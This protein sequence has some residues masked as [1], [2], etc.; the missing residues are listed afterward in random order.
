MQLFIPSGECYT[1]VKSLFKRTHLELVRVM[2]QTFF[3][4]YARMFAGVDHIELIHDEEDKDY[5]D[6]DRKEGAETRLI[7]PFPFES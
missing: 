4:T 6:G 2:K 3:D 1:K 7:G 5:F